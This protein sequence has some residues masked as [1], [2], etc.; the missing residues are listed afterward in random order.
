ME[1]LKWENII[2]E[3]KNQIDVFNNRLVKTKEEIGKLEGS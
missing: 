1:I 2:I 3:I